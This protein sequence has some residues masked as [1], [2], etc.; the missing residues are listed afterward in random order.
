M[1]VDSHQKVMGPFCGLVSVIVLAV[2]AAVDVQ[3]RQAGLAPPAGRERRHKVNTDP[4]P[5]TAVCGTTLSTTDATLRTVLAVGYVGDAIAYQRSNPAVY[6][7]AN[8][9]ESS[10][11]M[12][13]VQI[14]YSGFILSANSELQ[15]LTTEGTGSGTVL[16][17]IMSF[18][19]SDDAAEFFG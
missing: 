4:A 16:N 7:G 12:S 17:N 3:D 18:N 19:S 14:R 5:F 1:N 15:A 9:A 2:R 10:G 8:N 6:G 11:R 13:F